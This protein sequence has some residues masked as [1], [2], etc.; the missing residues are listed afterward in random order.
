MQAVQTLLAVIQSGGFVL[1]A[2]LSAYT[3]KGDAIIGGAVHIRISR[4]AMPEGEAPGHS[5]GLENLKIW[6]SQIE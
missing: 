6:K 3:N 1:E 5:R 2:A 4:A